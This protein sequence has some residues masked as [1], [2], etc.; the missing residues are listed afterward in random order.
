MAFV[1]PL[2]VEPLEDLDP[3]GLNGIEIHMLTV[4]ALSLEPLSLQ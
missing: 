1:G 3:L 4:E 2:V